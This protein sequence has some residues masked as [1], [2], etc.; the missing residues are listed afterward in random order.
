LQVIAGA[1]C[2]TT[3][4]TTSVAGVAVGAGTIATVTCMKDNP[5]VC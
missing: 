2:S 5:D 1:L 3:A 4:I